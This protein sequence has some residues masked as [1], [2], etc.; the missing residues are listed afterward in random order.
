[1]LNVITIVSNFDLMTVI[2]AE[3]VKLNHAQFII[4]LH[5][6]LLAILGATVTI[7][8]MNLASQFGSKKR[9]MTLIQKFISV[10]S[11]KFNARHDSSFNGKF[12][13]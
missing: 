9:T 5:V 7:I 6:L 10:V 3:H 12:Q 2:L 4:L 8:T 13:R 11:Q 1:M